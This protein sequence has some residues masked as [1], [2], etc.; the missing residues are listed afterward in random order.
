MTA[1]G[2]PGVALVGAEPQA[3]TFALRLEV[4]AAVLSVDLLAH[5]VLQLHQQLVVALP[6]QF[7]DA[8]QTK[9]VFPIYVAKASLSQRK[10]KRKVTGRLQKIPCIVFH[11]VAQGV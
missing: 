9:P 6:S 11:V 1:Q 8:F 7:V 3:V 10:I 4:E 2:V 5:P